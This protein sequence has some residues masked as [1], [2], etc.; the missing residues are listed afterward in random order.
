MGY[1]SPFPHQKINGLSIRACVQLH[2]AYVESLLLALAKEMSKS[3]LMFLPPL[4]KKHMCPFKNVYFLLYAI[5]K[6]PQRI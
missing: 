5:R 6:R 2:V 4:Q 3:L 1:S